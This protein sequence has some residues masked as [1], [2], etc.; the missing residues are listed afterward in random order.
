M[1]VALAGGVGGAKLAHGLYQTLPPETLTV[2]VNTAD[3]L[4]LFGLRM[5]PDA[6]TVMYTL[7]ELANPATGWGV[8]DESWQTLAMLE[9][10]G[11][12]IWFRVGDRDFATHIARSELLRAGQ[13]LSTALSSMARALGVRATLL[14]MSDTPVATMVDT[15]AGLLPFQDYFV[16]RQHRDPVHG[17]SFAGIEAATV[18]AAVSA[19]LAQAE[20]II[21]CPSNPIVSIGPI[22]AVPGLRE[23]LRQARAPRIAVS[24]IIGGKALRGP[25]DQ[26]LAGLG[27]ESSAL[28][29][30]RLYEGLIDGFVIDREDAEQQDAIAALGMR[31]LVTETIMRDVADRRRLAEAVLAFARG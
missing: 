7:A 2:V 28:G 22:L 9:R 11:R 21:F 1:I 4:D 27:H 26:M 3:D 31:V 5:C 16:R 20:A 23:Q 25:A 8:I 29:V 18:P 12:E 13:P 10:Y 15:P 6:D 30:A 17:I 14:P 24:P 19:A